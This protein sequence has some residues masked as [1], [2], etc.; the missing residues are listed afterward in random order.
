MSDTHQEAHT[1]PIKTPNQLLGTVVLAFAAPVFLIIGL[2]FF[3]S[4]GNKPGL[5]GANPELAVAKRLQKVGSVEIKVS[6]ANRVLHSGEEVY[7][8]QC[9]ACHGTGAA[10]APKFED[11]AAW[12]PRIKTG[13]EALVHSALQGKGAMPPQGG[14][15]LSDTEIARG[16]VYMANAAGA[17]FEEPAAPQPEG[18]AGK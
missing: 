2:A 7:K 11:A 5:G 14:G 16:V 9:S 6:D 1:G 3:V 13:L 10:G 15:E 18:E 12:G 4:V 17:K 8:A